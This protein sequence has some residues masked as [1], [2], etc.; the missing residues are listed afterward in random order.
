MTALNIIGAGLLL[1]DVLRFRQSHL[2]P[3][4][5]PQGAQLAAALQVLPL[6]R[7]LPYPAKYRNLPYPSRS[8][9]YLVLELRNRL[10]VRRVVRR[11]L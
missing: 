9:L 10:L 11:R 2:L 3:A 6:V 8:H 7:K 5:R 4:L 1:P